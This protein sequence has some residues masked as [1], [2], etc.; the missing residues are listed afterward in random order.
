STTYRLKNAQVADVA[1]AV[2]DFITKTLSVWTKGSQLTPFQE[3]QRDVIVATEPITNTLL[4]SAT[5]QHFD[6]IIQIIANLDTLPPQV[7]IQAMVAE[8]DLS[9]SE[10]FGV[11]LGLQTPILFRRGLTTT[12]GFTVNTAVAPN[13]GFNFNSTAALPNITGTG[14]GSPQ[15]V[16]F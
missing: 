5:P 16:G 8:V 10:E 13:P 3:I 11:E 7:V 9:G 1:A 15:V 12:D 14:I 4:I 2:N 6:E